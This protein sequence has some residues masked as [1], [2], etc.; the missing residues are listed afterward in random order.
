MNTEGPVIVTSTAHSSKIDTDTTIAEQQRREHKRHYKRIVAK[1][2]KDPAY[3]FDLLAHSKTDK[4]LREM[5][6]SKLIELGWEVEFIGK[7]K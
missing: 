4:A 7:S 3:W 6:E 2:E 1:Y 5:A